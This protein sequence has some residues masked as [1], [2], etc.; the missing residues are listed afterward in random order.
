VDFPQLYRN[1]GDGTFTDERQLAGLIFENPGYSLTAVAADFDGD[2]WPD[3][4]VACDSTPSLFLRNNHDETFTEQG[5]ERGVA[6]NEDGQEQAGMGLGIGD[7]S[8]QR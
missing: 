2:E 8:L 1:N 5:L 3:V 4:I 6:F 7:Y